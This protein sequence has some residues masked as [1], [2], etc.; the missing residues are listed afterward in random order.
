M[1][2]PLDEEWRLQFAWVKS[3]LGLALVAA[4]WACSPSARL[5]TPPPVAPSQTQSLAPAQ[6]E[7]IGSGPVRVAM[8][9]PLSGNTASVGRAMVNG[10]RLA[11]D[12]AAS[13]G[14]QSI[15]IVVKDA[16]GSAQSASRA[17]QQAIDEGAKLI[18][19]PLTADAV[20]LAGALARSLETP[21][22][23]FSSTSS[24][25]T[26]GVYL[27]SVLPEA[28]IMRALGFAR[29]QG[30]QTIAAVIPETALGFAQAEALRQAAGELGMR[31]VGIEMFAD[32]AR[33]RTAI[34]RLAP[35]MRSGQIDTL[36]LPDR[37]TAPSFG[38]LLEA[39]RVPRERLTIIGSADWEGDR[40]IIGQSYLAASLYPAIDPAGLTALAPLYRARFGSEPHPLTTLAYSAVM[41]A[42]TPSLSLATPAYGNGLLNPTGFSGRDG[43]FRFHFDGR[44]EYGLVM[45]QVRPGGAV[46]REPARMGGLPLASTGGLGIEA[47]IPP[48]AEFR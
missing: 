45:R 19:G 8:I 47:G 40:A 17:T 9:L 15:H 31:I 10:A 36:Y 39:A 24:V 13:A 28:E 27:L 42:N 29:A 1:I 12:E 35:A 41:L 38:I 44:A 21:L 7:V 32:E 30:R 43:P 11:M 46:T 2:G 20:G 3:V 48:A 14:R 22:I 34:E 18:L 25:A 6:G 37:A 33:A 26:D 16:G 23:G 4:L 5:E